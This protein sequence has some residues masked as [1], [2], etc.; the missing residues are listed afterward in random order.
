VIQHAML[1]VNARP[2]ANVWLDGRPVGET[3]LANLRVPAGEHE[4]I[5]RHPDLGERR[6]MTR[7]EPGRTTRVAVD[8][9]E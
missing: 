5:F 6:V 9:R 3:P 7:V 8:L 2:W 1:N 4:L